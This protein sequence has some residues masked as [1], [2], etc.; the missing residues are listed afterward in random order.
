MAT[1]NTLGVDALSIRG[2][3]GEYHRINRFFRSRAEAEAALASGDFTP[4]G[5][6][7]NAV[8]VLGEGLLVYNETTG[9]FDALDTATKAYID[10]K[11]AELIDDLDASDLD[12]ITE[13]AAAI[14]NNPNFWSDTSTAIT[15]VT[16]DLVSEVA[17][18]TSGDTTLTISKD[19]ILSALGISDGTDK[20]TFT[21]DLI[22]IDIDEALDYN[23]VFAAITVGDADSAT[24]LDLFTALQQFAKNSR[25][26]STL[27]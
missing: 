17:S 7:A 15:N 3:S 16:N 10:Q 24:E 21:E 18:R 23:G 4:Q 13:L 6:V 11:V 26:A 20:F 27:R 1:I 8:I 9:T 2:A 19:A 5:G 14:N 22:N 12:S 25:I